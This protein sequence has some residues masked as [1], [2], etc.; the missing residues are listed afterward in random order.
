MATEAFGKGH[1][2]G[3]RRRGSEPDSRCGLT[4]AGAV[5]FFRSSP[6]RRLCRREHCPPTA[7][8][9]TPGR[10]APG[11]GDL[12]GHLR[13]G[14]SVCVRESVIVLGSRDALPCEEPTCESLVSVKAASPME[15]GPE[16]RKAAKRSAFRVG[17]N[18]VADVES[19]GWRRRARLE[20][21]SQ[22]SRVIRSAK[23]RQE[24]R[25]FF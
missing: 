24:W 25:G 18:A 9:A 10:E 8:G 19:V 5:P 1:D 15:L 16:E 23:P 13:T 11:A 21:A 7:Q 6:P 2:A 3:I 14:R 20:T 17:R 22:L 12:T 4:P